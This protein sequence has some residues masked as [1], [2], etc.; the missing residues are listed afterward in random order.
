MKTTLAIDTATAR[1]QFAL[2]KG[3]ELLWLQTEDGA[4][5]HGD[6]LAN[7]ERLRQKKI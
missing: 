7:S 3:N 4:T 1:T 2:L 6:V 5:I